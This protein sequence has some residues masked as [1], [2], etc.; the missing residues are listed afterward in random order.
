VWA[1]DGGEISLPSWEAA[2]AYLIRVGRPVVRHLAVW[3][4]HGNRELVL[5]R[6][7]GGIREIASPQ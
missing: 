3:Q 1:R 4:T 7:A 5:R 6:S 2:R